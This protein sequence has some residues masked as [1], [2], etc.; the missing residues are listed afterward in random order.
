MAVDYAINYEDERFQKV[1]NEKQEALN[2]NDSIYDGMINQSDKF[3]QDQIDASKEWTDKQQQIQQENTDFAIEKVEQQKAEAEKAYQKEQQGA[4]IDWQKQSNQY[5]AEAEKRA[6]QGLSG[7]GYSESS[8]V[9]MYNTYQNRVSTARESYQK[10]VLNYDNAIKEAQLQ[11]NAKLAEIAYQALQK[12]LELSLSGFQYKNNLLIEQANK[13]LEIENMYHNRWQDV[14]NQI[15][16]EN[17]L[18]E[19]V[20]QYNE[21]MEMQKKQLEEQIRQHNE[22]IKLQQQQLEEERRQ[23][24]ESLKLEREKL[25]KSRSSGGSGSGRSSG[26]SRINKT[27][28]NDSKVAD[29]ASKTINTGVAMLDALVNSVVGGYKKR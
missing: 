24:N 25:A 22:S 11:N 16:T 26:N 20:R 21:S 5:G 14:L 29:K 6:A 10:A 7:T 23:Y 13:K 28:Q 8:Q 3:Y 18:A 4:Y 12:E 19:S 15:N 9:S 17:S 2:K 27:A 1:E